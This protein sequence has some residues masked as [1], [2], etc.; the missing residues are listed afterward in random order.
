MNKVKKY[1]I[2]S[3]FVIAFILCLI[4]PIKKYSTKSFE[5]KD[6]YSFNLDSSKEIVQDFKA[7]ADYEYVG[8]TYAN[9]EKIIKKGSL[10]V[11]LKSD[12]KEIISKSF[13]ISSLLNNV[14]IYLNQKIEKGKDYQ[15][16]I[17]NSSNENV[18]VYLT[19]S[20][21]D[22]ANLY[23]EGESVDDNAIVIFRN[24]KKSY[25]H[26]WYYFM[27]LSIYLVIIVVNKGEKKNV[28]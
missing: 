9:Y 12:E 16:V 2:P 27:A 1:I 14:T 13:K 15:L 6:V 17:K 21:I 20:T 10:I 5:R 25:K 3:L 11:T 22:N 23:Y 8:F 4:F 18:A 28:Q 7:D 26:L 19:K 24:E